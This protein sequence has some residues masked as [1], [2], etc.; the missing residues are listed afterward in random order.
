MISGRLHVVSGWLI[1]IADYTWRIVKDKILRLQGEEELCVGVFVF[2]YHLNLLKW[3]IVQKVCKCAFTESILWVQMTQIYM[4]N[5][6]NEEYILAFSLN[7]VSF[8]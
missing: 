7:S 3:K 8:A 2:F 6:V 4:L 1:I 5:M